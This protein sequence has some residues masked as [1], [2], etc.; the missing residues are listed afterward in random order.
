MAWRH[1]LELRYPDYHNAPVLP[2]GPRR[3]RYLI[4]GLA[5][6]LHGANRTGRPF[7]G[8]ASGRFLRA[9]LQRVA[10]RGARITNAVA[11]IP[12][13]NRPNAG[14]LDNCAHWLSEDLAAHLGQ[15][16]RVGILTL[17]RIAHA[18]VLRIL[19]L[20]IREYAFEHGRA[21][22]IGRAWWVCSYHPSRQNVNTGRLSA[23]MFD[24]A[25]SRLRDLVS[26]RVR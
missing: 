23:E 12:P 17:G 10:M 25:L 8:D 22:P 1:A 20:G 6:G 14:E 3:A 7:D 15:R 5:P 11:C 2:C 4:I 21:F 9:S 19:G 18:Q 16:R 24:A 13:G 26:P